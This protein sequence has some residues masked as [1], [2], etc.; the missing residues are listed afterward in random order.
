MKPAFKDL[1]YVLIQLFLFIIYL[2]RITA[3]DLQV[4]ILFQYAGLAVSIAGIVLLILSFVNLNKNLTPFPTPKGNSTLI[5]TGVYQY[6][7]HPVY[8]GILFMVA[9]YG[10]Y[11]QNTLRLL[12]SIVLLVLFIS[13][14]AY[15]ETLL[16]KKFPEYRHYQQRTAALLP[17]V[18]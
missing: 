8:A 7:R 6:I 11:S 16:I 4:W 18:Y 3:I 17:G 14:A 2:F 10:V 1:V 12:I 15:E 13:K 9:G 5:T